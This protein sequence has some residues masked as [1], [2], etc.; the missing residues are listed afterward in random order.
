MN[1]IQF[2]DR[3]YQVIV[4]DPPWPVKKLTRKAR[5]NQVEMDYRL[6]QVEDIHALPIYTITAD[7]CWVFLWPP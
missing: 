5:P 1:H 6:M 2:P 3:K 7:N 4:V